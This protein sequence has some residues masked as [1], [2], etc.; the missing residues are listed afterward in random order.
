MGQKAAMGQ[1]VDG[2]TTAAADGAAGMAA[3][4]DGKAE[5]GAV[6][7]GKGMDGK[8]ATELTAVADGSAAAE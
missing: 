7:H 8:T 2:G 4:V 3:A 6:A 1:L 5:I